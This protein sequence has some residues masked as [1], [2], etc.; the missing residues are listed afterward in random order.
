MQATK[1]SKLESDLQ[2]ANS[3]VD[4]L[5]AYTRRDNLVISGLPVESYAEASSSTEQDGRGESSEGTEKSLLKL[6]NDQLKVNVSPA[7]ISV[8]H[9]LRKRGGSSAVNSGPPAVI[10]RFTNRKTRDRVYNAR[11][12]LRNMNTRIF[13]N[14]DLNQSTN[15]LFFNA[16][17][18]VKSR[19]IHSAWTYTGNVFIK[20]TSTSRPRR[21][22]ST[23]DLSTN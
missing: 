23:D 5:E 21:I 13:I 1:I 3:R 17:H 4:E 6:F 19:I 7:D 16:R 11:R 10:V 18:L 9:R 8:A 14:E 20:E 2:K 12:E 22:T 15:K